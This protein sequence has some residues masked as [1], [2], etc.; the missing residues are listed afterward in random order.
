M[1]RCLLPPSAHV[2]LALGIVI[3]GLIAAV[4]L[5]HPISARVTDADLHNAQQLG[6]V[7]DLNLPP[8]SGWLI[9]HRKELWFLPGAGH[10]D[11]FYKQRTAYMD[12]AQAFLGGPNRRPCRPNRAN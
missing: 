5:S 7:K 12:H 10:T 3:A 4:V 1:T 11:A 9:T 8:L 6:I 2:F